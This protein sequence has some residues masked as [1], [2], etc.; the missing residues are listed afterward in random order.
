MTD[1]KVREHLIDVL[2]KA[3]PPYLLDYSGYGYVADDIF[4]AG[5][6]SASEVKTAREEALEEAAHTATSFLVGDP[7][8]GIPLRNPMAHEIAARIRALATPP[9]EPVPQEEVK[10]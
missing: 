9:A 7:A 2:E 4:A 3:L 1:P 10:F 6:V 8:N 5:Y